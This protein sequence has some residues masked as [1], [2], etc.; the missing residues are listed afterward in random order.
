MF[1][2]LVI[3]PGLL[4]AMVLG[5]FAFGTSRPKADLTY[6]N[7]S[8]IHTLDPARMSWTQDFRVALNIWEGL[9][10]SDS[11]TTE[12]VAG[13]AE[14]PP[15]V[16][17]DGLSWTFTIRSDARWSNGDPVTAMDFLRGWRRGME[18][19]TATDYVFLFA[20][21]IAGADEYIRWRQ[22]GVAVLTALSRAAAGW[23]L[24]PEQAEALAHDETLPEIRAA[25]HG[26][27]ADAPGEQIAKALHDSDLDWSAFHSRHFELHASELETRFSA[28]GIRAL[29]ARTLEVRLKEPCPYLLDL[30]AFPSFLPCHESIERLR[31]RFRGAP[32]TGQGL[33][34]YDPQW[35]KPDYHQNDYPGLIT[36]G[37]YRLA[38]W[39][40]KRRARLEVNPFYRDAAATTCRTV[41]MLVYENLSAAL[42]AYEAGEVDFLPAMDVP[43]DHEIARLAQSGQRPDF[44]LCHVLATYFFNFNCASPTVNGRAN[45]FVDARVRRAFALA[46]DKDALVEHV[47]RRG[48]RVAHSLVPPHSIAGYEPPPGLGYDVDRARALLA[49]A[50][51]PGGAGLP[52]VELLYVPA[53]ER[54]CQAVARMWERD[55]GVRIERRAL[56]SRTFAEEK[57]NQRFMIARGNWYADYYDPTTFLDCY[58]NGNGNNDSAFSNPEYD[59]LLDRAA[60]LRDPVKRMRALADAEA[61]LVEEELPLLPILH[62]AQPIAVQPWVHGIEPNPR[63][64][65]FFRHVT[66]HR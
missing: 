45:P 35:T 15:S 42:M 28:V 47:L 62:Y 54:V 37:P 4:A 25:L 3:A 27:D 8:G 10:T 12:P 51:Y 16:S 7:P 59:A 30:T 33:V 53:D 22:H 1:R 18:P 39:D 49:E 61:L 19:G 20:D 13:A 40:F 48:D 23:K 9:T 41:D 66:V 36:N 34:V 24:S 65:F 57:A 55:L 63:L 5:F 29:D 31:Q 60:H 14:F 43:Y 64:R 6:V 44:K 32:I 38:A 52:P 11:P 56:E 58:A 2:A 17:A 21:H 50:G 26:A 46:V